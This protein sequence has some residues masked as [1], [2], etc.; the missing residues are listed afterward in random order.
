MKL[1]PRLPVSNLIHLLNR[2]LNRASAI[3][4]LLVISATSVSAQE[5]P[6]PAFPGAEGYGKYT[7]GGTRELTVSG[8]V[9]PVTVKKV[10]NLNDSGPGSL[11]EAV[12]GS[13]PRVVIFEVSGTIEL[14]SPLNITGNNITIAGQTAPGDGICIS[15]Y[16]LGIQASNV[17]IRFLRVRLGD[18]NQVEA[19]AL[20]IARG[21]GNIIV[22]HCSVSFGVDEVFSFYEVSNVSVQWCIISES[23]YRSIHDKGTHGYGSLL[24]GVGVS[25][26]HNLYAHHSSRTPRFNGGRA[27]TA[28]RELVDFRNNII[29]NWGFNGAHGGEVGAR[30][31]VVNNYYKYGPATST[32]QRRYRIVEPT[33]DRNM[34]GT[35]IP[36]A[37]GN[38]TH[39]SQWFIEGNFVYGFPNITAD[40]WAGGVQ[41]NFGSWPEIKSA[42]S[43]EVAHPLPELSAWISYERVLRYG[44]AALPQRDSID[45]RIMSEVRTGTATYGASFGARRGIIDTPSDVGGYPVL[46]ST[47]APLDSDGDGIPDEW[48]VAN[49]LDAQSAADA[50][51]VTHA[52]GY[53]NL[54]RYLNAL[55]E[56]AMPG[57]VDDF[58]RSA[59]ELL[60]ADI[61]LE[62][63]EWP[64]GYVGY[65]HPDFGALLR[66][67]ARGWVYSYPLRAWVHPVASGP[68]ESLLY[69]SSTEDWLWT[70]EGFGGYYW[71]FAEQRWLKPAAVMH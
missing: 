53:T 69:D 19:D 42:E 5:L 26:H 2:R 3:G 27:N 18:A 56:A 9:I 61:G 7:L 13:N 46:E 64:E 60:P 11:R 38:P 30:I 70:G 52:S 6:L 17:V 23:L 50:H 39:T 41:G 14:R 12:A 31:N 20:T 24:G 34:S 68:A 36:D 55:A 57:A 51:I 16:P 21:R 47:A 66:P 62:S 48:E 58:V 10:T 22:D 1:L 35:M 25:F 45:A 67:A 44:G 63:S 43:F 65:K 59:T 29:Y 40:N 49:G 37:D 8:R 15:G 28:G 33:F 71:S 4:S 32:D 54:E